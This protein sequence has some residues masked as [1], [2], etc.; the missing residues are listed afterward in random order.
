M[1]RLGAFVFGFLLG[2]AVVFGSLHYHVV[3]AEDGMHVIRKQTT[4]FSQTYVDI[5]NYGYSDWAENQGLAFAI[6]QSNP[7]LLQGIASGTVQNAVGGAV[8]D[9]FQ[10]ANEVIQSSGFSIPQPQR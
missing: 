2:G 3:R 10:S 8:N 9:A 1:N 4:S 7:E 6:Q 5:R